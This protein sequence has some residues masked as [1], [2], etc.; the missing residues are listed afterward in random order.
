MGNA[1]AKRNSIENCP[2][3]N[4]NTLDGDLCYKLA[5]VATAGAAVRKVRK[6]ITA[7]MQVRKIV[8]GMGGAWR[9]VYW[10]L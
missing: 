3:A 5:T 9:G 4:L 6:F 10:S 2:N 8:V 7:T 1:R